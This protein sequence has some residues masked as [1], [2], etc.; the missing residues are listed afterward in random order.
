[1][2]GSGS[3]LGSGLPRKRRG[4]PSVR[5][6]PAHQPDPGLLAASTSKRWD[7]AVRHA[8]VEAWDPGRSGKLCRAMLASILLLSGHMLSS[9]RSPLP[10]AT[11][12]H[13]PRKVLIRSSTHKRKRGSPGEL[14]ASRKVRGHCPWTRPSEARPFL[15][16]SMSDAQGGK[17][18]RCCLP[19]AEAPAKLAGA[20]PRGLWLD[21]NTGQPVPGPQAPSTAQDQ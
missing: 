5:W 16:P 19:T 4:R 20:F 3:H 2:P 9:G 13:S 6:V 18:A 7:G 17:S 1:M 10:P 14:P 12:R 15:V 21:S 8:M 11:C